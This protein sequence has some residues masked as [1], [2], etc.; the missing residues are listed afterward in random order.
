VDP[1][2]VTQFNCLQQTGNFCLSSSMGPT[3]GG[4]RTSSTPT[5]KTSSTSSTSMS[6]LTNSGQA[7]TDA[8]FARLAV[9]GDDLVS[10]G[11]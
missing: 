4:R 7:A 2:V 9:Q 1:E 11:P 6:V 3:G 8:F 5:L 10:L